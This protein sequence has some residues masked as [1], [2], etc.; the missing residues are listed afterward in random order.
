MVSK[1]HCGQNYHLASDRLVIRGARREKGEKR[2]EGRRGG[3]PHSKH[4]S[5]CALLIWGHSGTSS[6][7]L[8][9]VAWQRLGHTGAVKSHY[10]NAGPLGASLYTAGNSF[11]FSSENS[12]DV[13]I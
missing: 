13:K 5:F 12:Q 7:R 2:V 9:W 10:S 8:R 1:P 6:R 3:I 4:L 11:V